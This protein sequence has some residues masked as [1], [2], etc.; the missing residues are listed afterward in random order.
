MPAARVAMCLPV[1]RVAGDRH[2]A[3][4]GVRDEHVAHRP[5]GAREDV[6]HAR[7]QLV[8]DQLREAQRAERR[9]GGRLEDD[10]VAG[11]ERRAQLPGRHV[12]G[13]V[14]GRDRGDDAHRV[15]ADHGRVA[16]EVLRDREALH[17]A[18][19]A[20]EEPEQVG[21]DGHLVDGGLGR[22]AGLEG[23]EAAEL[24][25]VLVEDVRHLEQREAAGLGR[26]QR[27]GL[28]R[29]G[30]GIDGGIDVGLAGRGHRGDGLRRSPGSRRSG[31]RRRRR[32]PSG[33]R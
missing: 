31:S 5:A 11:G 17:H 27:P 3:H 23:F 24:V 32:P 9:P 8:R 12:Q 29:L 14:P 1:D 7:R 16:L 21:A 28:E 26:G 22:L 25:G 6:E 30:G 4:L 10:G 2:H 19:G 13:V 33:R 20:R 18:A 15:P